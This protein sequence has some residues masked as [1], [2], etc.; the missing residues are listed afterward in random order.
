MI[1]F[2]PHLF[3][4]ETTYGAK[5]KLQMW[6][7]YDKSEVFFCIDKPIGASPRRYYE[8]GISTNRII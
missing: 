6:G 5:K 4:L 8:D 1:F 7:K 2:L 3:L